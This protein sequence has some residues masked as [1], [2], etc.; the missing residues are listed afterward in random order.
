M[1]SKL[2]QAAEEEQ[3]P[4]QLATQV[5]NRI[6]T[7]QGFAA[8]NTTSTS[9]SHNVKHRAH[10]ASQ[11]LSQPAGVKHV[12]YDNNLQKDHLSHK[13]QLKATLVLQY[14]QEGPITITNQ[15]ARRSR[16]PTRGRFTRTK[17]TSCRSPLRW[18]W[19]TLKSI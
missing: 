9:H 4:S 13:T 5:L 3:V 1:S 2:G 8:I 12:G 6:S 16:H 11:D 18:D 14:K 19:I 10:L 7:K 17:R 15:A